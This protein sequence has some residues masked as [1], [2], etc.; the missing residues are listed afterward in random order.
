[1]FEGDFADML[2][3]GRAE[4]LLCADPGARTPIGM[5]GNVTLFLWVTVSQLLWWQTIL[6]L[7]FENITFAYKYGIIKRVGNKRGDLHNQ[8]KR[9]I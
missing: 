7:G 3:R 2:M 5:S 8:L 6:A 9:H 1:M 4:G